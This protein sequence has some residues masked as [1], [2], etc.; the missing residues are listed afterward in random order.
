MASET[1]EQRIE[2]ACKD[3]EIPGL[4]M[5][6]GDREGKFRY[7]KAFGSRSLKDGKPDPMP[8]DAVMWLA[9]CTKLITSV[10]VMQCVEKGLLNLDDDV[11]PILPELKDI[12]VIVGFEK[13]SDGKD[14]PILK[15]N[16]KKIT[17]RHLMTHTSGFS[18]DFF[19]PVLM[20]FR[21]TQNF[22][23]TLFVT[24]PVLE[25]FYFPLMFEPGEG[26]D[27]GI[28]LDYAGWMVERVNGGITLD[29]YFN[30]NI[31]A[32]LGVKS[33]SFYPKKNPAIIGKLA[34]MSIREGG[35]TMFTNPANPDGKVVYIDDPIYNMEMPE[36]TGGS[37]LYGAPLDYFKLLHSL[38]CNDEKILRKAS[39]DDMF[40]PQLNSVGIKGFEA[41]LSIPD[42]NVQMSNLPAGTKVDYGLGSG[43]ILE[44]LPGRWREGTLYWSGY[45]NVHWYIDRKSGIASIM[46]SQLH[47]PGDPKFVEFSE[48]WSKE[49]FQKAEKEKL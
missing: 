13:D 30:K 35:V 6:A 10:A 16:T 41:K 23:P 32:P 36:C 45:P 3:L 29:E 15:K 2:R 14:K 44:D 27:Y 5:I 43:L 40:K 33:M 48:M 19:N 11:T 28:G 21:A 31:W 1:F 18:Y 22:T 17:L 26:W 4:V 25:A 46:G 12:D 49:I 38:V 9:S 7:E 39:V 34:D 20:R 24:K 37:G 42:V 47:A 8:L